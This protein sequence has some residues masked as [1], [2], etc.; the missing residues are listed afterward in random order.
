M[1]GNIL[2]SI[3]ASLAAVSGV[4]LG[5]AITDG[6]SFV[7]ADLNDVYGMGLYQDT[8]GYTWSDKKHGSSGCAEMGRLGKG[9]L[10]FSLIAIIMVGFSV[11]VHSLA[12]AA[13]NG[14]RCLAI[15]TLCLNSCAALSCFI[16]WV[17]AATMYSKE[18]CAAGLKLKDYFSLRYGL[19]VLV[20]GNVAMCFCAALSLVLVCTSPAE[21][22]DANAG[23]NELAPRPA[24]A[25]PTRP[26]YSAFP[27]TAT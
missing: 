1:P 24:T 5:G 7:E 26:H 15:T 6:R 9:L 11:L 22:P 14:R 13:E 2:H 25:T 3:A 20:F 19:Y 4:L 12:A 16:A 18:L 17:L 21:A 27:N 10:A 8:R 23:D